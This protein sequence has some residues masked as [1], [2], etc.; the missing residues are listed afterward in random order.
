MATI[1][2]VGNELIRVGFDA[3]SGALCSLFDVERDMEHVGNPA[4]GRLAR[5]M[6]PSAKWRS[7]FADTHDSGPPRIEHEDHLVRLIWD[8]LVAR[9]G[10]VRVDVSVTAEVR[11]GEAEVL[12]SL[13]VTNHGTD[14]IQEVRFPWFGGWTGTDGPEEKHAIAGVMPFELHPTRPELL[15]YNMAG[16]NRRRFIPY[17]NN[18]LLPFVDVGSQRAGV[19]YICYLDRPAI[20]GVVVEDLDPE[21]D[22]AAM[23]WS[24][25]HMPFIGPGSTWKS[26]VVGVGVHGGGWEPGADRLRAWLDKWWTP[27]DPPEW[28]RSSIGLQ[29]IM[30][31][32]FDGEPF[33]DWSDLP[34]LAEAGTRNGVHD[35]S[36]WDPIES[37]YARPDDGGY[38]EEYDEVH[39]LD[40]LRSS[41]QTLRD[42]GVN[43]SALV[44]MR[45]ARR[46]SQLWGPIDG[47]ARAIRTVMG[48]PVTGEWIDC[49]QLGSNHAS[50]RTEYLGQEGTALC[51]RPRDSRDRAL[52]TMSQTLDLGFP[53]IFVDQAFEH[54]PCLSTMHGHR[55]PDD[56]HEATLEW[57]GDVLH[58][59]RDRD[60]N[61]YVLGESTDIYG[62]Q[63][64][65]L[66][67]NWNWITQE[68]A[69]IRYVLPEVLQAWPVDHQIPVLN[70]LFAM[71]FLAAFTSAELTGTIADFPR[72]ASHVAQLAALRSATSSWVAKGQFRNRQGMRS[73]HECCFAYRSS[74][75]L[76]FVAAELTGRP[77][78]VVIE[79]TDVGRFEGAGPWSLWRAR[80]GVASPK[81]VNGPDG[82]LRAPLL[83]YEVVVWTAPH[84][85]GG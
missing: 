3:E 28:L 42:A 76:S 70:R 47:E 67:W 83:P 11:P 4:Y 13:A 62:L 7:R 27:T 26:P 14:V 68:P 41:L 61:G 31:R 44:N 45:L 32:S 82:N 56:T 57:V 71:G 19:S 60:K 50:F 66:M 21:P 49:T 85:D 55:S 65:D 52:K 79:P 58:D 54:V 33:H 6:V 43:S 74:T 23:S 77:A 40:S 25:V 20:G 22:A 29:V 1:V 78:T 51:Q 16:S 10:A 64:L 30:M 84:R 15:A 48:S 59:V 8:G 39:S 2:E 38:W 81:L 24:W 34:A 73:T 9:D 18:M 37:V 80:N 36:I 35:I 75:G 12:F 69:V 17:T 72:F 53:S 63:R 5:V 46:R